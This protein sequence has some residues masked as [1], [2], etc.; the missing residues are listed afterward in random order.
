MHQINENSKIQDIE[1]L[2]KIYLSFL[3]IF[4]KIGFNR[5]FSQDTAHEQ[6]L[7]DQP[8]FYL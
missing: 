3:K 1:N 6:A 5:R 7:L 8:S 2:D 4:L